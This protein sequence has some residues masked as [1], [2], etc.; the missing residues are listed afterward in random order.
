MMCREDISSAA[1]GNK[2]KA[3]FFFF[4]LPRLSFEVHAITF[5]FSFCWA[6]IMGRRKELQL[7]EYWRYVETWIPLF[8]VPSCIVE[9]CIYLP[10]SAENEF[11]NV[12]TD[13]VFERFF[14]SRPTAVFLCSLIFSLR[15]EYEM[16][17]CCLYILCYEWFN[18]LALL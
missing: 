14:V 2:Y 13:V 5:L 16:W 6:Y 1:S 17:K 7:I 4:S 10:F 8:F 18:S 9:R 12:L 15:N 3:T 11:Q